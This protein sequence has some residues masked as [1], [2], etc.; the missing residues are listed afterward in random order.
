MSLLIELP[1]EVEK[2]LRERA[3]AARQTPEAFA[4]V[5]LVSSM[6][7]PVNEGVG[8]SPLGWLPTLPGQP[9][10]AAMSPDDYCRLLGIEDLRDKSIALVQEVFPHPQTIEMEVKQDPE[11]CANCL[12]IHVSVPGDRAVLRAAYNQYISRWVRETPSDK[13]LYVRMS[14]RGRDA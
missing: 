11:E 9:C 13:R 8:R 5:M 4:A 1:G 12:T 3:G 6:N 7:T 14:Y 10:T 2:V